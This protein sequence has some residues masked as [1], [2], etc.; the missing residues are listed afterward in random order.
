MVRE[1][2]VSAV[3]VRLSVMVAA[4]VCA[5]IVG[6]ILT[7]SSW[8]GCPNEQVRLEEAYAS[9]LPDCR[10]YEQ[11]SPVQ[12]NLADARGGSD[13][14]QA[15]PDRKPRE[16]APSEEP[17]VTFSSIIPFPGV[18]GSVEFPEYLSA[19]IDVAGNEGWSTVG[20]EPPSAV[21]S[22]SEVRGNTEDLAKTIVF[23]N[24]QP[25]LAN[26]GNNEGGNYYVRDNATATYELFVNGGLGAFTFA[27][28]TPD[29]SRILFESPAALLPGA[30]QGA[31]NLYEWDEG[32]ISLVA[33]DAVAG[34]NNYE[35]GE[36]GAKGRY[37]TQYTISEEGSRVFFTDLDTG[38]VKAYVESH[39]ATQV[40]EIS[41]GS[42]QWRAATPNGK[43]TFYTEGKVLYRFNVEAAEKGERKAP[44][45]IGVAGV[46]GTL[47][48]SNDGAY[49][50]YAARNGGSIYEWHE[51]KSTQVLQANS[52]LAVEN[53]SG[54]CACNG[55]GA[56]EGEKTARVSVSGQALLF[57]S[58]APLTD[59]DNNKENELYIY[60]APTEKLT[61]VSCNP[62]G[63]PASAPAYLVQAPPSPASPGAPQVFLTR[64][65]SED[66]DRVFFQTEEALVP[67]D[68]NNHMDVYEWEREGAGSC[69]EGSGNGSGGCL[70]LLSAG[71]SSTAESYFGNADAE[72]NNVFLFTRQSLVGQDQDYNSDLYDARVEG[73]IV[74][75]SRSSAAPCTSEEMCRGVLPSAPLFGTP[76]SVSF[77]GTG[78]LA[79][80][81]KSQTVPKPKSTSTK[82]KPKKRR[83]RRKGHKAKKSGGHLERGRVA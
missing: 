55:L 67:E 41:S 54:A 18:L 4:F 77:S 21:G 1:E 80:Q 17:T 27:D 10:A 42:A 74:S 69:T 25:P 48:V 51:G 31:P 56:G 65:L 12:K 5:C 57:T 81:S 64:N 59:Y 40:I 11:V 16:G 26:G 72:G 2:R 28:A 6:S 78:N 44:E 24:D 29:G 7:A 14:V 76:A 61:C 49:A 53:W 75:Q 62:S 71:T 23:S 43:F 79:S 3:P 30:D 34:P 9:T 38:K 52:S 47:G 8:A 82:A 36:A 13:H 73:G 22:H 32:S 68:I 66:G 63:V 83:K 39:A 58:G 45:Q 70:Y 19:R 20:L 15:S 50:Y 35:G 37:Y 60:N 46:V 33:G